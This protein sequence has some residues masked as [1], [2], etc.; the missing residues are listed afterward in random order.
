M[1]TETTGASTMALPICFKLDILGVCDVQVDS[2]SLSGGSAGNS[3][4]YNS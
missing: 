2:T 4:H 3:Y 1:E